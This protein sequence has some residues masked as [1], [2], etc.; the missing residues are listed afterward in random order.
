MSKRRLHLDLE[1]FSE[2]DLGDAGVFRYAEHPSTE[3]LVMGYAFDNEDV[4]QWFPGTPLPDEV[5]QHVL[6][7][8][9]IRAHNAQFERVVLNGV[10]GEAIGFPF[11]EIAQTVC[12]AAKCAANGIP[13][14]LSDASKAL[15]TFPKSDAG[16]MEMLQLCKPRKPTKNDLT[17]R[18]TLETAPEKFEAMYAY[19]LDDVKA[20]RDV[21]HAVPDLSVAEQAVYEL[22]QIINARGIAVDLV[23]IDNIMAVVTEYK[24]FLAFQC[25]LE[26][27][28]KPTQRDKI[29][30]WIRAE[31]RWPGLVDM[32]ADTVK[33]LVANES[34]PDEV[35]KV[36]RIYSTYNAKAITKYAAIL[37]AVCKDSRLRGMFMYH[38]ANT[39]R[40]SSLIV[41]LQNL[42]R[43]VI[44]DPETAIEAFATRD[45]DWIR[46]LYGGV[47]PIKVAASCV[48]SVLVAAHDK[49][50]VFPDYA[51]IESR[52][53]AWLFGEDWKLDAFRK[54]DRREGPDSY[55]AVYSKFFLIP[56]E[57]VK[58]KQRQVGKVVD[59][60]C[61]GPD[62]PVLTES[63]GYVRIADIKPGHKVWD[64]LQWV[65]HHG[66]LKQGVRPV[67]TVAGVKVTADHLIATQGTWTRASQLASSESTL[68][69][70]LATGSANLPWWHFWAVLRSKFSA[71]VAHRR[72]ESTTTTCA[73]GAAP[74]AAAAQRKK[75]DTGPKN[76]GP[77]QTSSPTTHIVDGCL[78]VFRRV[79]TDATTQGI[80][81]TRI[82]E[83]EEFSY[84][85][86][87]AKTAG[88]FWR[89]LSSLK[90]G[91]TKRWSWIVP[92]LTEDTSRGTSALLAGE[93]TAKTSAPSE[94]CRRES[95]PLKESLP[96]YDLA[97]CGALH[98]YTV[99]SERGPLLV[100]NC[101]YEGGVGA[102]VT[103]SETYGLNLA[104]MTEA[105]LP[106]LPRE[107]LETSEW[108]WGKFGA[109]SGLDHDTYV[110]CDGLKQLWRAAHPAIRQGWKD[111][112]DAA[113]KAV[114]FP[115]TAFSL[116]NGRVAFKVVSYKGR[117]WLYLKLP[118]GRL[119]A[120]YNPRWIESKTIVVKNKWGKDEERIVPGELRYWGVDTDT[121][122]WME[123][124]SYGGR[125]C[126][127]IV[128]AGSRD[129]LVNGML[130]LEQRGYPLVGS[131]HD[132]PIAEVPKD[133]GSF[134]EAGAIICELPDWAAGLPVAVGGHRGKR[135]RK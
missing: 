84:L 113:E 51:G 31:G 134:D 94:P 126:E 125:W 130:K 119:L 24:E 61:F 110:A 26:T 118:S 12:T 62:T 10:A 38:G 23:A 49:E 63:A 82:T 32:Q 45:L 8:G 98:S 127:N 73:T 85:S 39:G 64:G 112:K 90:V 58:P 28:L 42:F 93:S 60:A 135:Y 115:G 43:P 108:M 86:R 101:G 7:G 104:E 65:R 71:R 102:F 40:W 13:R 76:F 66:L 128:Q 89:T 80:Q 77:T 131:V 74:G 83:A 111:L 47:D 120:Y 56:V 103:M 11:I 36:L 106:T 22:D 124:S 6:S 15:G 129:I 88:L 30:E 99:L 19:N 107:I 116:Q 109:N 132:E 68:R 92:T 105:V 41:Q 17:A 27:G 100:H 95:T 91:T 16:R 79:L 5:V 25:E 52:F 53:N 37:A 35:K 117:N 3:V 97:L 81:R 87:G 114:Q 21:D 78:A 29:A 20:E 46:T 96:T 133:F 33:A 67:V 9:E 122:R 4:K 54:Y 44:D 2:C 48:R 55:V 121:R 1:T 50:L 14:S 75:P 34:V 70:A 18:Y 123:I 59:L 57:D 69:Q 72:T